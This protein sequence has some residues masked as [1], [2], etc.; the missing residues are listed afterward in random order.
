MPR[1]AERTLS[2]RPVHGSSSNRG[3]A[4]LS[5]RQTAVLLV[6]LF[7]SGF[8]AFGWNRVFPLSSGNELFLADQLAEGRMPYRDF[9]MAVPPLLPLI[10]R[11]ITEAFGRYFAAFFVAF[12]VLRLG[13]LVLCTAWLSRLLPVRAVALAA[14]VGFVAAAGDIA[15]APDLYHHL[16]P[17]FAIGAGWMV[18]RA[19]SSS[20][21]RAYGWML[22]AGML[23]GLSSMVKQTSG[24]VTVL[25]LTPCII[26][27]GWRI[28]G[29]R[30]G[31]GMAASF[32]AGVA[33]PVLGIA[34]WLGLHGALVPF[35]KQ[36]V[37]T[38][39]SSKGGLGGSLWRMATAS[40]GVLRRPLLL[41]AAL[42]A[43]VPLTLR[44][45]AY[46]KLAWLLV[47]LLT[48][49]LLPQG[50]V[51]F[52]QLAACYVAFG[53]SASVAAIYIRRFHFSADP[54][55]ARLAL[56]GLL[57]F[58]TAFGLA[59]SWPAY[60]PMILP[61]FVLVAGVIG[62]GLEKQQKKLYPALAVAGLLLLLTTSFVR[63]V[64]IPFD[65]GS[66]REPSL[67]SPR[68]ATTLPE[69]RGLALSR[70]TAEVLESATRAVRVRA[71]AGD[72]LLV[73]PLM[74]DF[75]SLTEL[76]PETYAKSHYIDICPD[77]I[78]KRDLATVLSRPPAFLIVQ[79]SGE[80]LLR[81][82]ELEFRGGRPSGQR[83]MQDGIKRLL[84]TD[85]YVQVDS[86]A[87]T[88]AD[89]I[90]VWVRP[91]RLEPRIQEQPASS[92]ASA[93]RWSHGNGASGAGLVLGAPASVQHTSQPVIGR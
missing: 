86:E 52:P 37:L 88:G 13:A 43:L 23:V 51:R 93:T 60:E 5:E 67:L 36:T 35:L 29:A 34:V 30:R 11:V 63:R 57:C 16:I 83:L 42:V 74:A 69:L 68:G 53:G 1:A 2:G 76:Q 78:A 66:W 84:I 27:S 22:I 75:Y 85:R 32:L 14:A 3:M 77:G 25:L 20:G 45:T 73:F 8:A 81:V 4:G 46:S 82:L 79:F 72:K 44:W 17:A 47:G 61:G 49:I 18:D 26:Y 6:L 28:F 54:R 48:L 7:A 65:W 56:A 38:G 31:A 12:F 92:T 19:Y 80:A 40:L 50:S 41:G 62:Q 58:A 59:M 90:E 87:V 9:Y 21:S 24:P 89:P 33:L 64:L 70:R 71:H 39:P 10:Y 15:E 55:D 91:D